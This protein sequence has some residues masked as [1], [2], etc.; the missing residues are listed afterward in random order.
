MM[1]DTDLSDRLTWGHMLL[2]LKFAVTKQ[3]VFQT[4]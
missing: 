4:K 3:R 1:I 2:S